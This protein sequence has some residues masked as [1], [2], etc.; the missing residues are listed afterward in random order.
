MSAKGPQEARPV[1]IVG[2][3]WPGIPVRD[4]AATARADA[5]WRP[6]AKGLTPHGLRHSHKPWWMS[7]AYLPNSRMSEWA[8]MTARCRP[9][10]R[11]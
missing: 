5:C 1:P 6:I 9:V 2:E 10:I 3:P 11:M 7:W 8:T 4:R